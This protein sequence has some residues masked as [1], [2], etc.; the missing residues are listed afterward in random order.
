MDPRHP[1][2]LFLH[3]VQ[4]PARYVGGEHGEIR[5]D[6][7]E[8]D[9]RICLAFP[10]AYEIGM[11]HLGYRILYALLN[12]DPRILAER[13]YAPWDDLERELRAR[14][15]PLRSL[16]SWRALREFDVVGFSLQYELTFTNVLLMLDLG[17]IPLRAESRGEDD[18]L[19]VFGGPV[20][21][22]AEAMSPFAD[23]MLIGDGE[24]RAPQMVLAW[25]EGRRAGLSRAE[26]LRRLAGIEGVYVPSLYSVALE[27]KTG[28]LVV[29]R[30]LVPE[31]PLPI[32][33]TFV[34][35]L[36]DYPFPAVG[37]VASTETTFDRVSIEIARGC[38]E[39]CRFCQAGMIYRP[40][41]ERSP[42]AIVETI[43]RALAEGG[44]DEA[45]L[46][47][48][49]TAD[50]SAIAPLVRE[51]VRRFAPQG[52]ALGVSS[53]RAYGLP[54]SVLD[55]MA[56]TRATG[57]TFAPEA[58]TQR[59]RDVINK[60]VTE[61]QLLETAERVFSR[62]WSRMKLYFM[63]GLPT[64]RDED[65]L[66]IIETGRRALEVGRRI[67]G[68]G[69]AH[70]TVSVSTHVPK[71][72]TPFQWCAMDRPETIARKQALL[73]EAARGT[74]LELRLH[75]CDGSVLEGVLARG[76]RR[77]ADVIERAYRAGARFDSW[78]ERLRLETWR[79]A[80]AAHG[81]DP[82]ERLRTWPIDARLPWGHVDVGLE[83]GFLA[84]E[85]RRALA[86]RLSPPCGKVAG[87]FLHP[88]RLEE[89]IAETRRLV[90]YDCGIACDLQAMREDRIE[91][92]RSLPQVAQHPRR[93]A[94]ASA[95]SERRPYAGV[96]QGPRLRLRLRHTKLGR[97]AYQSHL[98]L[99]R[100]LPR[101]LRRA[102]LAPTWTEGYRPRPRMSFGPA[103]PLGV[104]SLAELVDVEIVDIGLDPDA[105][106]ERLDAT[107]S[108]G[109]RWTGARRLAPHEPAIGRIVGA[110]E[111]VAG[112]PRVLLPSGA[113]RSST[114]WEWIEAR[115]RGA[116]RVRRE[117]SG[118]LGRWI[119]VGAQLESVEP[120]AGGEQLAQ[121]G[122]VGAFWPVRFRTKIGA[123]GGVRPAEVIEALLGLPAAEAM[124]VPIV[125]TAL[126]ATSAD[127]AVCAFDATA[128]DLDA[129]NAPAATTVQA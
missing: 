22:H 52:V 7:N 12:S 108:E 121:A 128:R 66:G 107:G 25:V 67:L 55:D 71:P 15:E 113:P 99:V 37:P 102:G 42:T 88:T 40:V 63:I 89:A 75:G 97:A 43:E 4:R 32:R 92:L 78:E 125:R 79:E 41:R 82:L 33:R 127:R 80:F 124:A 83:D 77:L 16:E 85:Y 61:A 106:R 93:E 8:V 28:L 27:P 117:V 48:L 26:R 76:D 47:S 91:H 19:V 9:A 98:D 109:I 2:A 53:L 104:C 50:Y 49:S 30:P 110:A 20:A 65:V 36:D 68:R 60:N 74:G 23:C 69:R 44:Y 31:A 64:E 46:T 34:P 58:G 96:D 54:E 18:P 115:A 122:L 62:G 95:R 5:K 57:L 123:Q 17:G 112:V 35:R 10:D 72:H 118:G 120:G 94:R 101:M 70:V 3:R 51:V 11:S 84:R 14:D 6:W 13:C 126:L 119:D 90:C 129:A 114:C 73:R 105:I 21:T 29:D 86:G 56:C 59:M 1:Y 87:A 116:L 100:L 81:I 38:T 111:W 45:S 24:E 103:L 39:G